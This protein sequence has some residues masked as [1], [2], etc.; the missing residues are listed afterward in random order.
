MVLEFY[1]RI[2]MN[3]TN[4]SLANVALTAIESQIGADLDLIILERPIGQTDTDL[5]VGITTTV[6]G[7]KITHETWI[8]NNYG[9]QVVDYSANS[10]DV[11]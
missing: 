7:N 8:K 9:A 1:V 6:F 4:F 5:E 2:K 3:F 10:Q 11:P